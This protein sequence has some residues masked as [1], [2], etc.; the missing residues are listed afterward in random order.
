MIRT[1]QSEWQELN[2]GAYP[3]LQA[4]GWRERN[5]RCIGYGR[6]ICTDARD[7]VVLLSMR[8]SAW[9]RNCIRHGARNRGRVRRGL[10][11]GRQGKNFVKGNEVSSSSIRRN[12]ATCV[13]SDARS[14]ETILVGSLDL[15]SVSSIR[16]MLAQLSSIQPSP[17]KIFHHQVT[18]PALW[19]ETH[20]YMLSMAYLY[21]VPA[22]LCPDRPSLTATLNLSLWSS[23][24]IS[25]F[26]TE[27]H[28]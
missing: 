11:C 17:V 27:Q 19:S 9:T 20:P 5:S 24:N 3:N 23:R 7:F 12:S 10:G 21:L 15:V 4:Q 26:L 18:L 14:R 28:S 13:K 25:G 6:R 1:L 2:S 8:E 22:I 16:A